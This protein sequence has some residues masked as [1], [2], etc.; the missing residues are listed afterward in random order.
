MGNSERIGL[1]ITSDTQFQIGSTIL[2]L[3]EV[4][5]VNNLDVP[6]DGSAM[7]SSPSGHP[8]DF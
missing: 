1:G 2:A 8:R 7:I 5:S 6:R 3:H 4:M